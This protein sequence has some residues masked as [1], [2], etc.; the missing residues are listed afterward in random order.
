MQKKGPPLV[1]DEC[2]PTKKPRLNVSRKKRS[3]QIL[4]SGNQVQSVAH[5]VPQPIE[6]EV[7]QSEAHLDVELPPEPIKEEM[8]QS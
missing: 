5:V 3:V 6:E 4:V 1:V 2:W 8:L 7:L